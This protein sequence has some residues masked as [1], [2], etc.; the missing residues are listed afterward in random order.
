MKPIFHANQEQASAIA[1]NEHNVFMGLLDKQPPEGSTLYGIGEGGNDAVF[2]KS[3]NTVGY[4]TSPLRRP[5]G[6]YRVKESW[7]WCGWT[8]EGE[9]NIEYKD[10]STKWITFEDEDK[11]NDEWIAISDN[12]HVLSFPIGKDELYHFTDENP[13]PLPWNSSITM[14]AEAAR[15][16]LDIKTSV[17]RVQELMAKE[18]LLS[19]FRP[20]KITGMEWLG[21]DEKGTLKQFIAHWNALYAKPRKT[22]DGYECFPYNHMTIDQYWAYAQANINSAN[23]KYIGGNSCIYWRR[24]F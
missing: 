19:G 23:W 13:N 6:T 11:F 15:W 5:T 21:L 18:I 20:Q 17:K 4:T 16:E 3:M 14:P 1:Q 22:K 12:L 8:E 10:G 9:V 24:S 2:R 7:R